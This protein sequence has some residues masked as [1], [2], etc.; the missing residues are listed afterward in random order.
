MGWHRRS[1]VL[2]QKAGTILVS[3]LLRAIASFGTPKGHSVCVGPPP[4]GA[5]RSLRDSVRVWSEFAEGRT[6]EVCASRS[7]V[8]GGPDSRPTRRSPGPWS[9]GHV[10]EGS[11]KRLPLLVVRFT[12]EL[13]ERGRAPSGAHFRLPLYVDSYGSPSATP[14]SKPAVDVSFDDGA[15]WTAASV[16]AEGVHWNAQFDHPRGAEYVS[17]R[18]STHDARRRAVE[19]TLFRAYWLSE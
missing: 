15:S 6:N 3:G 7:R 12:P 8:A 1:F 10:D 11:P 18:T 13:D 17:L 2:R 4:R 5:A 14:A 9:R 19:Q 16:V